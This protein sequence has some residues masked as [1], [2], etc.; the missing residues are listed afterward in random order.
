[1]AFSKKEDESKRGVSRQ[2]TISPAISWKG[3]G[4]IA[5][6][7]AILNMGLMF[8]LFMNPLSHQIIFSTSNGQ[9]PKLIAVWTQLDPI[10]SLLT[11][12]PALTITPI[13]YSAIFAIT[14]ETLPGK[15]GMRK[16]LSYGIMLW[17]LI[18]VFFELFTPRGL[19]GE[20][21]HLLAFELCLWFAALIA[22]GVMMGVIYSKMQKKRRIE[23]S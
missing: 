6:S 18:A 11:L 5:P 13:I 21:V 20:P 8:L 23:V 17:A 15:T 14:Y 10:P 22:V 16:G 9:N 1:M 3:L 7:A 4:I 2:V 12:L 19:L